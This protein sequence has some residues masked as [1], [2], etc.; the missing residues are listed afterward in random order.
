M[1]VSETQ[2]PGVGTRYRIAFPDRSS[3]TILLHNNGTRDTY[4]SGDADGDSDRLFSVSESQS[5]KIAEIFDGT[6][7]EP[8][9]DDVDTVFEEAR[10]R[11]VTVPSSSSL[12]GQTIRA[13][14]V[15]SKTGASIIAVQRGTKTLSNPTPDTV[16]RADDVLVVVG[17]EENHSALEELLNEAT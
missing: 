9:P 10:I 14:G 2:L 12:A 4:W 1:K 5:R 8:V 13:A 6:Y 15:R 3:F 16:L 17:S 11:W 7:F